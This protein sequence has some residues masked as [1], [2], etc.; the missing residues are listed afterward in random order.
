M[1]VTLSGTTIT[2][3]D[4][5]TQTSSA[6]GFGQTWQNL[7]GSRVN[8]TSYQN[9]TGRVIMV[10]L[11]NS[12]TSDVQASSDN[13]TWIQVGREVAGATYPNQFLV[14]INWYYRTSVAGG[15]RFWWAELR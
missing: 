1:A 2:F 8:G 6:V 12:L 15:T 14:P 9:T 4:S 13:A 11:G 10:S 7:S 3:N 5:T